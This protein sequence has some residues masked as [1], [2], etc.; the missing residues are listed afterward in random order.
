M[1]AVP[2]RPRAVTRLLDAVVATAVDCVSSLAVACWLASM[3]HCHTAE[4]GAM[5]PVVLKRQ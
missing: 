1:M 5:Q 3:L 4:Q 2:H